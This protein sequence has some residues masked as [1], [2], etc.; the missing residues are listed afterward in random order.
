[1]SLN[2]TVCLIIVPARVGVGDVVGK[3]NHGLGTCFRICPWVGFL[4]SVGG[5][6]I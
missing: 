2:P 5:V 6:L 3:A 1:M 4:G